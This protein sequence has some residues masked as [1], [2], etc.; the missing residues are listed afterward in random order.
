MPAAPTEMVCRLHTVESAA[1]AG[2]LDTPSVAA[3]ESAT[4]TH[5]TDPTKPAKSDCE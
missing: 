3:T 5:G 2:S 1:L 4:V